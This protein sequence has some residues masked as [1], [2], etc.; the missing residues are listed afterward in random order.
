MDFG[1]PVEIQKIKFLAR[2]DD[3][4]VIPGSDYE[5]LYWDNE[6]KSFAKKTATSDSLVFE[7]VPSN[8]LYLLHYY[9]EGVEERIFTYENDKQIWY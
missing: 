4:N 2:N 1:K 7:N 6:W 8:A 5:L 9:G 3:N